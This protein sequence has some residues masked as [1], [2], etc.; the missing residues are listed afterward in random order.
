MG[1]TVATGIAIASSDD[2]TT[3]TVTH[4]VDG[5][6]IDVSYDGAEHRVRLLNVDTPES[7][8]PEEP[9]E[10]MGPEATAFLRDRLPVG[11][12]VRLEYDEERLDG[13]DRELAG[14]FLGDALVNAE[15]ARAGLGV[16]MSVG[17]NTRFHAEVQAAE[18]EARSL[19]RG[20]FSEELTCTVPARVAQLEATAAT[21]AGAEPAQGAGLEA[22]E[23]H[24]TELAE[25]AAAATTLI[26][27]LDG[28]RR[29]FPLAAFDAVEITRLRARVD[30]VDRRVRAAQSRNQAAR[31]V[32]ESRLEAER[33]AAEEA[34]RQAAEA[35]ARRAAEEAARQ[36]AETERTRSSGDS[37]S[38]GSGSAGS[39]SS[40][41]GSGSSSSGSSS[42]GGSSSGGSSSGGSSSGGSGSGSSGGGSGPSGSGSGPS[43][44][45]SGSGSSG[46]GSSG[47]GSPGGYDGY[48][49]CRAYGPGGTSIDEKGRPYT[50][51]DCTTKQPIG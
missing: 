14:V 37:G 20:L 17:D 26:G 42:S 40:S 36:A 13:Y 27:F 8:D 31:A 47:G 4:V 11:T 22:I 41:G 30:D 48:T 35:E 7:V 32:E 29:V 43:G 21:V 38:T 9:V 49:G 18:E 3:A 10:C 34:A 5:D 16:A 44:G 28:D 46:G 19:G 1:A 25:V 12:E 6:T 23:A 24:A 2:G 33:Q 51:I 45:G 50:K 39:R 15:I